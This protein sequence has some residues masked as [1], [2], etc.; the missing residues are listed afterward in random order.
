MFVPER[1]EPPADRMRI[2]LTEDDLRQMALVWLAQGRSIPSPDQMRELAK[3]KAL[4]RILA[5]EAVALGLDQ[6]DEIIGRRLAQ[7]MDFLLADLSTIE[8]PSEAELRRWY[9]EHQDRFVVPPRASFRHLYFSQDKRGLEGARSHAEKVLP[10]L[11]GIGPNQPQLSS[12]ADR[13]M[14]RD[15][16]GGRSPLE[17]S[18]EFGPDFAEKLLALKLGQWQGPIQSGYGWHLVWIDTLQPGHTADFETIKD[19]IRSA[20]L[21]E[22]YQKIRARAY[23]EML[24]RYTIVMPDPETVDFSPARAAAKVA[25]PKPL[26]R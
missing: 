5:R 2:E 1:A 22:R 3:Q 25:A 7:K 23:E 17:I 14:F 26:T 18:K 4:Q 9:T 15:Y 12:M 20:W 8:A 10:T 24:T 13:F 21:E 16:Y 11:A 19:D 6:D